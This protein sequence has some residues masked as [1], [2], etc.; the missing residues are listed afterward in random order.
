MSLLLMS[1]PRKLPARLLGD[2]VADDSAELDDLVAGWEWNRS[3]A[4]GERRRGENAV[5]LQT[6]AAWTRYG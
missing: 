3:E 6:N 1:T 5:V 4:G 2:V